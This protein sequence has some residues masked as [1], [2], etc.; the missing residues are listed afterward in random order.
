M[1]ELEIQASEKVAR[2]LNDT[3]TLKLC[4]NFVL[5]LIT[6]CLDFFFALNQCS[7]SQ[8]ANYGFTNI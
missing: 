6:R 7:M 8:G 3:I 5:T 2:K 4:D 1:T